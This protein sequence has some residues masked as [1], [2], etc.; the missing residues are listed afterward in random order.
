MGIKWRGYGYV[1]WDGSAHFGSKQPNMLRTADGGAH[2]EKSNSTLYPGPGTRHL[3]LGAAHQGPLLLNQGVDGNDGWAL[4]FSEFSVGAEYAQNTGCGTSR[5]VLQLAAV[6]TSSDGWPVVNR[7]N[8]PPADLTLR[9]PPGVKAGPSTSPWSIALGEAMVI[10]CA[11]INRWHAGWFAAMAPAPALAPT[12]AQQTPDEGHNCSLAGPFY[13]SDHLPMVDCIASCESDSSCQGFTWKHV[14]TPA[15]SGVAVTV[16]CTAKAGQPC[17]YFQ[18]KAAITGRA[19]TPLFDCWEKGGLPPPAPVPPPPSPQPPWAGPHSCCCTSCTLPPECKGAG[20]AGVTAA[21]PSMMWRD[22]KVAKTFI[23]NATTTGENSELRWHLVFAAVDKTTQ[24]ALR[25]SVV[26]AANGTILS[27]V[28]ASAS[29]HGAPLAP[30]RQF[31]YDGL[32][33]AKTD[34]LMAFGGSVLVVNGEKTASTQPQP[35][36]LCV[37]EKLV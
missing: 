21:C 3:D 29:G 7:S 36:Q 27:V 11:E 1:N 26:V 9:A 5:A 13:R 24:Q 8:G 33:G 17:C 4:Y 35:E 15:G 31:R 19:S 2:W 25:Y 14:D 34:D 12:T 20:G 18:T 6:D 32:A 30:L 23:T 10:V 28:N 37:A 22:P 16:N